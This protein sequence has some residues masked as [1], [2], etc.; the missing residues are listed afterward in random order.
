L[1]ISFIICQSSLF[2][3]RIRSFL[4]AELLPNKKHAAIDLAMAAVYMNNPL[5]LKVN[6]L[7]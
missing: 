7:V 5:I 2:V 1:A 4:N 6:V 3:T